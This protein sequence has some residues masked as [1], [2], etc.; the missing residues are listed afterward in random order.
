MGIQPQGDV[1]VSD[2]LDRIE[3]KLDRLLEI[4]EGRAPGELRRRARADVINYL[5]RHK[6]RLDKGHGGEEGRS[7]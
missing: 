6:I 3:E 1:V 7:T 4:F 2:Q 5:T